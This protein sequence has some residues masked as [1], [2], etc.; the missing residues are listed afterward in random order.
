MIFPELNLE[1]YSTSHLSCP[2]CTC[3]YTYMC[4]CIYVYTLCIHIFM[5]LVSKMV[6]VCDYL[7]HILYLQTSR[8]EWRSLVLLFLMN[9]RV[10]NMSNYSSSSFMEPFIFHL[11]IPQDRSL[12]FILLNTKRE[13]TDV[14]TEN[15]TWMLLWAKNGQNEEW[16]LTSTFFHP[17]CCNPRIISSITNN[18][19]RFFSY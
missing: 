5:N 8:D 4:S 14:D 7:K 3:A 19:R 15:H 2:V 11:K 10:R 1:F 16:K 6:Q 9:N 17:N 18:K 12:K 13:K